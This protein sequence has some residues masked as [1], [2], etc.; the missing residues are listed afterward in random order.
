M[1]AEPSS[2]NISS[3]I[4]SLFQ[5]H[6]PNFLT[7][8]Q[9]GQWRV[10]ISGITMNRLE[11][12]RGRISGS[13]RP[14]SGSWL[15]EHSQQG[16]LCSTHSFISFT[17]FSMMHASDLLHNRGLPVYQICSVHCRNTFRQSETQKEQLQNLCNLQASLSCNPKRKEACDRG[18]RKRGHRGQRMSAVDVLYHYDITCTQTERMITV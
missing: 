17:L 16:S 12:H 13:P 18:E 11:S 4:Q 8:S 9:A 1:G 5:I 3:E 7:R 10:S 2:N 15:G 6:F 14:P